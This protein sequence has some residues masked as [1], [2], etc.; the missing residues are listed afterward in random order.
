M[1]LVQ[2]IVFMNNDEFISCGDVVSKE[3]AM[4]SVIVWD[5]ESGARLSDQI[6]HEKF[7][8][9]SLAIHPHR[10]LFYA[11]THGN[12]IA[13]FASRPPFKMNRHR[14]FESSSHSTQ[15][16]YIGCDIN[17]SGGVIASGSADGPV[18]VYSLES[19]KMIERIDA[20][21]KQ[22][23]LDV[24]FRRMI[25]NESSDSDISNKCFLATSSWTGLIRVF[26]F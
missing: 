15:G 4:Y 9:T 23:C 24:K 25:R 16:Y 21:S 7:I 17:P 1:G 18:F 3:S 8:C 26:Q 5:M 10:A 14:R 13:E 6:F 19:G 22:P 20:F 11:Q 12:Y 2:D